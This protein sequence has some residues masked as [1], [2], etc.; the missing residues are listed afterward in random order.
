MQ[1]V[2]GVVGVVLLGVLADVLLPAG[3]INKYVK[4]IFTVLLVLVLLA[5]V[6]AIFRQQ[7][8][9]LDVDDWSLNGYQQD[10][11]YIQIVDDDILR[12]AIRTRFPTVD[13]LE[14]DEA[15]VRVYVHGDVPDGLVAYVAMVYGLSA[16]EVTVYAQ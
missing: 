15:E 12:S 2:L 6:G 5:P 7:S 8:L 3:Q 10:A 13:R 4:G 16:N 14:V 11:H 1:W 9:S